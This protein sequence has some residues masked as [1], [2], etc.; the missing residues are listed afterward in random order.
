MCVR[1]VSDRKREIKRERE[2]ER[3]GEG[4]KGSGGEREW[5]GRRALEREGRGVTMSIVVDFPVDP[6]AAIAR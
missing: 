5:V 6:E 2:R 3:K 1:G 4:N